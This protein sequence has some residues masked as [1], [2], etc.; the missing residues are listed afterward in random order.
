[1]TYLHYCPVLKYL[2]LCI[3]PGNFSVGYSHDGEKIV[4]LGCDGEL[5]IWTGLDDDDC[6]N[7]LIGDSGLSMTVSEKRIYVGPSESNLVQ[8]YS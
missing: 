4:T 7:F 3:S 5:R 2:C 8:A 6:E 1:M